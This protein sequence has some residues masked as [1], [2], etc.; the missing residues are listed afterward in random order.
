LEESH[1]F[2]KTA[3]RIMREGMEGEKERDKCCDLSY[4][5]LKY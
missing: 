4:D 1:K 3:K 5:N 2:E